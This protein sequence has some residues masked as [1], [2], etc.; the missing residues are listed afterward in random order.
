MNEEQED[1]GRRMSPGNVED[2]TWNRTVFPSECPCSDCRERL[3][4]L[5][6][7]FREELESREAVERPDGLV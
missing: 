4:S 6:P 7:E 3:R 1:A 2:R 5:T